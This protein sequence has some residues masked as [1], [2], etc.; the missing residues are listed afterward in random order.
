[1]KRKLSKFLRS[2]KAEII[3][4]EII[5]ARGDL[6]INLDKSAFRLQMINS[7][8]RVSDREQKPHHAECSLGS[9][10]ITI[11][12]PSTLE[13]IQVEVTEHLYFSTLQDKGQEMRDLETISL[14][15]TALSTVSF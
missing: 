7:E 11:R 3:K 13:A 10:F 1:M 4:A 2:Y 9:L 15:S 6:K 8:S 12:N 14:Y 5:L